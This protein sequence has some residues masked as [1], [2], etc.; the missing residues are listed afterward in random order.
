[1][2]IDQCQNYRYDCDNWD[3]QEGRLSIAVPT[4]KVGIEY[5][6]EGDREQYC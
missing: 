1:M 6:F 3:K 5:K 4:R 2:S